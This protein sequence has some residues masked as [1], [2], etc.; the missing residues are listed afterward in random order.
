MLTTRWGVHNHNPCTCLRICRIHLLR[1]P[2][3]PPVSRR[4]HDYSGH[5]C[6]ALLPQVLSWQ[7]DNN[8]FGDRHSQRMSRANLDAETRRR[9]K[10][11]GPN[12]QPTAAPANARR[13]PGREKSQERKAVLAY[14]FLTPRHLATSALGDQVTRDHSWLCFSI[15]VAAAAI[16][17]VIDDL[18]GTHFASAAWQWHNRSDRPFT[19]HRLQKSP[20]IQQ[21]TPLKLLAERLLVQSSRGDC[22]SFER[23]VGAL[24]DAALSPSAESVVA[25]RVMRLSA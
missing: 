13:R 25:T 19:T 12:R 8:F 22:P 1:L 11:C 24:V 6:P 14:R 10:K 21:R 2:Q 23:M 9:I 5:R 4:P 7:A 20:A 18:C 17:L 3:L 15:L 16:T